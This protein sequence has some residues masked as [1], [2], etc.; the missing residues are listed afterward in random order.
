MNKKVLI[1]GFSGL[2]ITGVGMCVFTLFFSSG[3]LWDSFVLLYTEKK[4]GALISIGSLP[5]LP[6]F[7]YLLRQQRYATANGLVGVLIALVG[8]VALLKAI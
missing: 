6:F 8:V 5:N 7:F 4:L 1:G 3:N 2:C